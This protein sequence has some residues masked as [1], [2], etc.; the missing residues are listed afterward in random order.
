MRDTK[1]DP[2]LHKKP[3]LRSVQPAYRGVYP[4]TLKNAHVNILPIWKHMRIHSGDGS[5]DNKKMLRAD[6]PC[7]SLGS[8]HIGYRRI[9]PIVTQNTAPQSHE[10]DTHNCGDLI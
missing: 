4:A 6:N 8:A 2:T 9:H 7:S 10:C 3:F 1:D 5:A